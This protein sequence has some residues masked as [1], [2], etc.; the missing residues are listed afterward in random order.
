MSGADGHK[1]MLY[2]DEESEYS[3]QYSDGEFSDYSDPELGEVN[4]F[5][6]RFEEDDI[7]EEDEKADEKYRAFQA[8]RLQHPDEMEI[9][10]PPRTDIPSVEEQMKCFYT[11]LASE[12]FEKDKAWAVPVI[13]AWWIAQQAS[14]AFREKHSELAAWKKSQRKHMGILTLGP[15]LSF[16]EEYE[17]M[18][19]QKT[20]LAIKEA[21][22]KDEQ[23]ALHAK[24]VALN[25]SMKAAK[26]RQ[27]TGKARWMYKAFGLN[28]RSKWHDGRRSG[29]VKFAEKQ[30]RCQTAATTTIKSAEGDGKRATRKEKQKKARAEAVEYAQKMLVDK[31]TPTPIEIDVEEDNAD[32]MTAAL[33]FI[34]KECIE[35]IEKREAYEKKEADEAKQTAEKKKQAEKFTLVTSKKTKSKNPTIALGFKGLVSQAIERRR[36]TDAVYDERCNG[37]GDLGDKSKLE[38]VLTRTQLCRSVTGPVKKRCYHKQCRFAHSVDELVKKM[39]R[40]GNGCRFVRKQE[41][42]QY[43]NAKFGKTGKTCSCYHPGEHKLGFAQRMGLEVTKDMEAQNKPTQTPKP[44]LPKPTPTPVQISAPALTLTPPQMNKVWANNTNEQSLGKHRLQSRSQNYD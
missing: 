9:I 7:I 11:F 8:S 20:Q 6:D 41:N 33:A 5:G 4:I 23:D 42:G 38:K 26:A 18:R 37:F 32:E 29:A 21:A 14:K 35:K 36:N 25:S 17:K 40:F 31:T 28:K 12:Q 34:D 24:S 2:S 15:I 10:L 44:A 16:E 3:H 43:E 1:N 27:K 13:E 39:C 30:Y 22:D 19:A